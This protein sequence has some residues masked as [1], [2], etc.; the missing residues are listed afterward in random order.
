MINTR[1]YFDNLAS[2]LSNK[3]GLDLIFQLYLTE[4]IRKSIIQDKVE[5]YR[6]IQKELTH[7]DQDEQR[8]RGPP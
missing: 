6:I 3:K 8:Q 1:H 2:P 7:E 5:A 4:N